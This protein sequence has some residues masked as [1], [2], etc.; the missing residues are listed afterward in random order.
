M[1][2]QEK[3]MNNTLSIEELRSDKLLGVT[4]DIEYL[5]YTDP[6]ECL[7]SYYS[8]YEIDEINAIELPNI[9][10]YQK[11]KPFA[12]DAEN[13]MNYFEQVQCEE[14]C[15]NFDYAEVNRL[16][17]PLNKYLATISNTYECIGRIKDEEVK[18]IWEKLKK[19]WNKE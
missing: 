9:F 1:T 13:V 5:V 12:L 6:E 8:D 3:I 17:E 19:E 2:M 14:D 18:P 11:T 15:D 4:D 16:L 10:V 7:E